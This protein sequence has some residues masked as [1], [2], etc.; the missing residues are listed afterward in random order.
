[1]KSILIHPF[2]VGTDIGPV[3]RMLPD[4]NLASLSK[5]QT[6]P[7]RGRIGVGTFVSLTGGSALAGTPSEIK[8]DRG[9]DDG[10][11]VKPWPSS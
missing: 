10:L 3:A 11:G 2:A 9:H 8:E 7:T 5:T 1:M 4:A 6:C